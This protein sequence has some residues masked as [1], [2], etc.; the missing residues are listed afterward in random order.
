MVVSYDVGS[1]PITANSSATLL[2]TCQHSDC[3]CGSVLCGV[4]V[5]NVLVL[6]Y[7]LRGEVSVGLVL[8]DAV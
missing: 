7:M 5:F 4:H 8:A 2:A 3:W 1:G 6:F